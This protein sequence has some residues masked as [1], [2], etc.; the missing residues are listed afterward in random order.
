MSWPSPEAVRRELDIAQN[1]LEDARRSA[2]QAKEDIEFWH[3][4]E[5]HIKLD[6]EVAECFTLPCPYCGAGPGQECDMGDGRTRSR[7]E[8]HTAR[9]KL[10]VSKS[11]TEGG[12]S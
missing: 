6:I 1:R 3:Q 9:N 5:L 11:K 4:Q 10:T 2:A 8:R 7:W 12:M